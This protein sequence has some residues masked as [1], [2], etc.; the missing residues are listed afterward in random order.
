MDEKKTAAEE[1][2]EKIIRN[3]ELSSERLVEYKRYKKSPLIIIKGE[4]IIEIPPED[5][6]LTTTPRGKSTD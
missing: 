5:I 2:R 4:E 6:P 1:L 3:I